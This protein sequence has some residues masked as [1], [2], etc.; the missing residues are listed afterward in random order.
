LEAVHILNAAN[1]QRNMHGCGAQLMLRTVQG[2]GE[3]LAVGGGDATGEGSGEVAG[4]G[5][6]DWST[7]YIQAG[8]RGRRGTKFV[9][10]TQRR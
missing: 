7:A 9:E 8:R 5:T 1:A 3:G 2:G 6:G 4:E 10:N